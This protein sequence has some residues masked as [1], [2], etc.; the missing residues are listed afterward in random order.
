MPV[1]SPRLMLAAI[2]A[3]IMAVIVVALM[4][5]IV[6]PTK[7]QNWFGGSSK[8]P[9]AQFK[10]IQ[11]SLELGPKRTLE[12]SPRDGFAV[13]ELPL[14]NPAIESE[15]IINWLIK[16]SDDKTQVQL[17]W[18]SGTR[19]YDQQLRFRSSNYAE[20]IHLGGDPRWMGA[21]P[22][23]RL[24]VKG[25]PLTLGDFVTFR[26]DSVRTRLQLMWD[27][28]FGFK[29]WAISDLNFIEATDSTENY[30]FNVTIMLAVL[31][32]WLSYAAS[33]WV[34]GRPVALN[35]LLLIGIMGWFIADFRWQIELFHKASDTWG[36]F[37]GKTLA[38]KHLAADDHEYYWLVE[39]LKPFVANDKASSAPYLIHFNADERYDLGKLTY[40]T[41]PHPLLN[42]DW[43]PPAGTTFG[44]V[45]TASRY[46]AEKRMLTLSNGVVIAAE[47]VA[48][49][50]S[51]AVYRAR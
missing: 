37:A 49:R 40:Y 15:P 1:R 48:Q 41:A 4:Q 12:L 23:L 7:A 6:L 39:N 35:A 27:G 3:I 30:Y 8:I 16:R 9:A 22:V 51:A 19:T 20:E 26:A 50:G 47:R 10:T 25:G 43:V 21:S 18:V 34:R 38:E 45:G 14:S 42:L 11:G 24:I 13:I 36:R 17:Q 28:W 31:L 44:V 5:A 29:P 33:Q 2:C 32:L 46:D